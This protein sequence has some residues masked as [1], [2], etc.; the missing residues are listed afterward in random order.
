MNFV[1]DLQSICNHII[2]ENVYKLS[3][4]HIAYRFLTRNINILNF[5]FNDSDKYIYTYQP[6]GFI[7]LLATVQNKKY[8]N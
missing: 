1:K 3:N 7:L 8:I 6:I 2:I 5:I 4:D